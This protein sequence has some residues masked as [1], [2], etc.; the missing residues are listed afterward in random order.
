MNKLSAVVLAGGLGTRLRPY[1]LLLPKPMLPVGPKPILEHII[2]WLRENGI[3]SMVISIG[4]LGRMI[5]EYL[6][7]GSELG[8]NIKYTRSNRPLGIAGQLRAAQDQVNGR[9]LCLY[10]DAILDFKLE[11]LLNFHEKRRP[12][13]TMALMRYETHLKYGFIE[14][15]K[16]G[17]VTSWKEKPAIGG[18]INIGCYVMEKEFFKYIPEGKVYGM[19]EAIEAARS[20]GETICAL[21]VK[22]KFIDIGDKR[23]YLEASEIFLK[24]YGKIP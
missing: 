17:D 13:V 9:F 23:S 2:E 21:K 14:S 5:E 22:G 24:K 8:V 6:R 11:K 1:T 20:N 4:Y 19:K 10:G 16:K 15:D 18:N 7:S 3:K 12:L